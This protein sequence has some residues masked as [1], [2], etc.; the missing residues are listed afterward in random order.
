MLQCLNCKNVNL[1]AFISRFTLKCFFLRTFVKYMVL[2]Y[3]WSLV[4]N[5]DKAI[6]RLN[7][8]FFLLHFCLLNYFLK[9]IAVWEEKCTLK[10]RTF[11]EFSFEHSFRHR[12][13]LNSVSRHRNTAVQLARPLL[14]NNVYN[15]RG[16]AWFLRSSLHLITIVSE[17]SMK[18]EERKSFFYWMNKK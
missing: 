6:Y 18:N 1:C 13:W 16:R 8:H 17:E 4:Q 3:G 9:Q 15:P 7:F 12:W 2:M 10:C 14:C 5:R 11:Q